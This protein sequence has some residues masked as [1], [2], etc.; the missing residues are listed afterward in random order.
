MTF[1]EVASFACR[2]TLEEGGCVDC[3]MDVRDVP[4]SWLQ[5]CVQWAYPLNVELPISMQ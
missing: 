3:G 5:F 1:E 4:S 2:I